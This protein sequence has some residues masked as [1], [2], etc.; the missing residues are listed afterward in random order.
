MFLAAP[1]WHWWLAPV[2]VASGVLLILAM[3]AGYLLQVTKGRYPQRP[4]RRD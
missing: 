4:A 3:V 2:L 1:V